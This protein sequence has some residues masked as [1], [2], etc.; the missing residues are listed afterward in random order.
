MIQRF[1]IFIWLLLI[2]AACQRDNNIVPTLANPEA[3]ATGFILTENAPPT[4]YDMVSFPR[5]DANL[6]ELAG[7]R[8]EMEFEFIGHFSRTPREANARTQAT[9]SYQ[10]L[11]SSR[12]VIAQIQ[13]DLQGENEP[14]QYEG[15]RLGPDAFLVRDG[16]CLTNAGDDAAVVAD[17][18]AG[19]I[20]GGVE[21][22]TT[23]AQKQVINGVQVWRYDFVL[24]ALRLPNNVTFSDD[25]VI[26]SLVHELWVAPEY[27]AVVRYYVTMEVEN[28]I[29]NES[30]LPVSGSLIIRYDLY[31][32]GIVPSINIPFGC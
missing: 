6:E 32:I 31:D 25:S 22:A 24:E 9:V 30:P 19:D 28:V 8:Y 11:N 14:L 3:I 5:I 4:G 18:S 26:L 17:L 29:V 20:L 7:W 2:V 10:Q 21:I 27:D 15:V 12:R 23:A 1:S 13:Q 16:V